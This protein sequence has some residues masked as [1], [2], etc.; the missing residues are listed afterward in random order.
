[1]QAADALTA[2]ERG[3]DSSEALDVGGSPPVAGIEQTPIT[4]AQTLGT[5][6]PHAN[7]WDVK[8]F[9]W[10]YPAIADWM[11]ANPDKTLGQC[12]KHFTVA[13]A[14]L[15][16][17][18]NSDAFKAYLAERQQRMSLAVDVTLT[19]QLHS[20]A[21][22]ALEI[23]EMRLREERN[24]IPLKDA[25]ETA[26]MALKALGYSPSR[27]QPPQGTVNVN[28]G[29]HVSADDLQAARERLRAQQR[30]FIQRAEGDSQA[31]PAPSAPEAGTAP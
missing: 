28:V 15:S 5:N 14:W 30:E 8:G 1:M 29:V 12:A 23:S 4:Y 26:A 25:N 13:Q 19:E 6:K 27:H 11:L 10:W 9:L 16:R 17:I 22:Q 31:L 21:S 3:L 2:L 7:T 24:K 20:V 18:I